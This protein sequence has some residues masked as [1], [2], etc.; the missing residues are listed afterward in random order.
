MGGLYVAKLQINEL[1][2]DS[3]V[4]V[5]FN[6]RIMKRD[7]NHMTETIEKVKIRK[8]TVR[9]A[10]ERYDFP[11]SCLRPSLKGLRERK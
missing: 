7:E 8:M 2:P 6:F 4:I 3:N 11:R 9:D 10:S 1:L 5:S